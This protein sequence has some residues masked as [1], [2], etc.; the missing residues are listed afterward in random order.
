LLD[1]L[2]RGRDR[3]E[4]RTDAVDI[5]T[6]EVGPALILHEY[7]MQGPPITDDF[8][9]KLVDQVLLPLLRP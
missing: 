5:R 1:A 9:V 4:V 8:V 2:A 3:G 6:A 7:L